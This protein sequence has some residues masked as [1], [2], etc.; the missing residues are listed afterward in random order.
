MNR[1]RQSGFSVIEA[2]VA[3][4]VLAVALVPLLTLQIQLTRAAEHQQ[5]LRER[6][7]SQRNAVAV[8]RDVNFMETPQGVIALH[9]EMRLSWRAR[10]TSPVVKSTRQGAADGDFEVALYQVEVAISENESVLTTFSLMEL[11]WR[12]VQ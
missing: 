9:G 6:I 1:A 12:R 11:G 10:P 2:L 8:L 3:I 7:T 4:A 5:A